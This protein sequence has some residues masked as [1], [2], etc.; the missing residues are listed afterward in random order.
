MINEFKSNTCVTRKH[1]YS[2]GNFS[3]FGIT[4]DV[5]FAS[6]IQRKHQK[7]S[8]LIAAGHTF[9]RIPNLHGLMSVPLRWVYS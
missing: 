1:V 8:A 5:C 4:S 7:L 6:E 2:Y 3:E 9:L